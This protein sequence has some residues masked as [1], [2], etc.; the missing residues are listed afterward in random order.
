MA[1]GDESGDLGLEGEGVRGV[2]KGW[3]AEVEVAGL[4]IV[5]VVVVDEAR[6][7]VVFWARCCGRVEERGEEQGKRRQRVQI[8]FAGFSV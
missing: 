4:A 2:L 6:R 5:V 3:A 7:R 8:I 1:D